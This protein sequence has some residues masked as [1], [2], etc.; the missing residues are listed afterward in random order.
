MTHD[1]KPPRPPGAEPLDAEAFIRGTS[2]SL[3]STPG[4]RRQLYERV[5]AQLRE[6]LPEALVLVASFDGQASALHHEAC[7]GPPRLVAALDGALGEAAGG[8]TVPCPAED[9]ARLILPRLQ[10]TPGADSTDQDGIPSAFAPPGL[11]VAAEAWAN[12]SCYGLGLTHEG[13]LLGVVTL[14]QPRPLSPAEQRW[15]EALAQHA[16]IA[17]ARGQVEAVDETA[18]LVGLDG[19]VQACSRQTVERL[20]HTPEDPTWPAGHGR[21]TQDEQDMRRERAKVLLTQGR[22][23]RYTERADDRIRDCSLHPVVG[24]DGHVR[25][26]AGFAR[27]ITEQVRLQERVRRAATFQRALFSSLSEGVLVMDD[28]GVITDCNRALQ[29]SLGMGQGELLGRSGAEICAQR[30]CWE[31]WEGEQL[32]LLEPG[33]D[34]VQLELRMRRPDG[35]SFTARVGASRIDLAGSEGTVVWTVRDVTDEL[36]R[37]EQLEHMAT[38]DDLTGLPNRVL[39]HDRLGRAREAGRRYGTSFAALMLDLDG[40]KAVNDTLGHEVGDQLLT[41]LGERLRG[42][43]RA[44]DTVSRLGGDEFA[45]LLPTSIST[46]QALQVGDKLLEIIEQPFELAGQQL[47][48][49]ASIGVAM[50]PEH[51][52]AGDDLLARAD[53]AM[54]TAKRAGGRRVQLADGEPGS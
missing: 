41:T 37:F 34:P 44:A 15:I 24:E 5:A 46:A 52:D 51:D 17:L 38:H 6:A 1:S 20:L 13:T 33:G 43:L 25:A 26:F 48:V 10:P 28:E 14:L 49:S 8:R 9:Q 36:L 22:A 3:G 19:R 31:R 27:D 35:A 39:F 23:V 12:P 47:R 30:A 53:Q 16:G 54:Y 18:L 29:R 4:G 32:P 2:L 40:F 7:A 21:G 42:C 50:F 45:V 11:R